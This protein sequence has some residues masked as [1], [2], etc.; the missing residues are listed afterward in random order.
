METN[1]KVQDY[2][3]GKQVR[4]SPPYSSKARILDF[5]YAFN[6]LAGTIG[7]S[8][9]LLTTWNDS[10]MA[11]IIALLGI[12]AFA[13]ASYR[14]INKATEMEK[15]FI[16]P[17]RLDIVNSS[18]FKVSKKSFLLAD[19]SDFKFLEKERYE[20]HP[21]KGETFDYLG[22]QAEQEVI[23]DLHSE[24]KVSFLYNGKQIRFGKDLASWEFNDLEV[25]LYDLTGNDFRYTDK[26]EQETFPQD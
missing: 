20:P 4:L 22:F 14:F 1:F 21:L 16:N 19:I 8:Y 26:Y 15:L 13:I 11:S 6:F 23:Q 3:A 25:L 12:V 17:Q 7:F 18:L 24:G 10:F 2:Q 9:L 5:F